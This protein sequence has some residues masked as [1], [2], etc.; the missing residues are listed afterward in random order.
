MKPG[1]GRN[2]IAVDASIATLTELSRLEAIDA[3]RV[4][5]ART[6]A[7]AV[8]ADPTNASL[9]REYRAA[10][11]ALREDQDTSGDEFAQLLAD[12]SAQ[13]LDAQETGMS[14]PRT[15]D[16]GDS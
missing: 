7:D 5:A 15:R 3:A 14:E 1:A 16:C 10:E 6:L 13:V 2:R 4:A 8:D 11:Q 9:W 12:L